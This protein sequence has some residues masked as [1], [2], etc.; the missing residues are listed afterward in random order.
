[1]GAGSG[2]ASSSSS[3]TTF[4]LGAEAADAVEV[5]EFFGA[6]CDPECFGAASDSSVA[7]FVVAGSTAVGADVTAAGCVAAGF[8][9]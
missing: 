3:A 2:V 4:L 5:F 7:I 6:G 1:M 8:V 9:G